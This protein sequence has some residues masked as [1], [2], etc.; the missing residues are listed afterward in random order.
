MADVINVNEFIFGRT[1][2]EKKLA[3]LDSLSDADIRKATSATILRIYNECHGDRDRFY[4]SSDRRAGNNWDS[5]IEFIYEWKGNAMICLYVQNSSTDSSECEYY[6]TFNSGNRYNGYCDHLNK[7]FTYDANDIANVIR[8][9]LKEYVY[10]TYIEKAE[11][12][13]K[14]RIAKVL[15]WKIYNPVCNQ[16]YDEWRCKYESGGWNS[17]TPNKDRYHRA[18]KAVKAYVEEHI[19]EL[20]GKSV[21]EL[22]NIYRNIFRN[23][24]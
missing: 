7:R 21:E 3:V 14:E 10:Y 1:K 15:N 17:R 18:E 22:Q 6:N 2:A 13:R 11:R 23:T 19:D 8:C 20:D 24:D 16:F 4:I 5:T 12:E 9:I